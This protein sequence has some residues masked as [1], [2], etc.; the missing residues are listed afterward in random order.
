LKLTDNT[1]LNKVVTP[2]NYDKYVDHVKSVLSDKLALHYGRCSIAVNDSFFRQCVA[3]DYL[4]L[5]LEP[6]DSPLVNEQNVAR[7]QF[8]FGLSRKYR[9][10]K[11]LRWWLQGQLVDR[12][13]DEQIISRNNAMRPPIAFLDYH[14]D[15][16]T[17]ILQEYFVPI[18]NFKPFMDEMRQILLQ[19][20]VNVLSMTLR[21]LKPDDNS[22][23][24][25]AEH[26]AIAIVL[27]MN[28]GLD[29]SSQQQAKAW[30]REIVDSLLRYSGTYY[31]TY[32]SYPSLEQFRLAYPK[33]RIFQRLKNRYDPSAMFGNE[34]Y[35]TY[36]PQ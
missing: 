18:E 27:Y 22:F 23:L 21:Y 34:F 9:W 8:L 16:D 32:Q 14:S 4:Q 3:V 28:V 24:N 29:Q 10:G 2:V 35:K 20:Q 19:N 7:D 13:G 5:A 33:W 31:L 1:W 25:Y 36:F 17:D 12:P 15:S 30:T 11:S 6:G 26:E